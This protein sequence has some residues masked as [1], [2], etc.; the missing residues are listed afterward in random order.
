[1]GFPGFLDQDGDPGNEAQF[2][3]VNVEVLVIQ[4]FRH[5]FLPFLAKLRQ[6]TTTEDEDDD[7][8][9]DDFSPESPHR[10][11]LSNSS[12]PITFTPSLRALSSF[13]P[14]DSPATT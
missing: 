9:E 2:E 14:G 10:T 7:E 12:S 8:D 3:L 13:E 11:S 5:A 1:M 4:V 6:P